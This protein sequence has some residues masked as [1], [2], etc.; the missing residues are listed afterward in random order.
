MRW[1]RRLFRLPDPQPR[2]W[3]LWLNGEP[4]GWLKVVALEKP[5]A[6]LPINLIGPFRSEVDCEDFCD[7]AN[8]DGNRPYHASTG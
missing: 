1:L 3:A 2:V 7:R 4:G 6:S 8:A 5:T